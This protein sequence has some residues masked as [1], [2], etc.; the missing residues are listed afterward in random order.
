MSKK[1]TPAPI[2]AAPIKTAMVLAAGMGNRMR[3]LT[4]STPKPL[5]PMLGR[6]L[7][8]WTFDRL[9]AGGITDF[10]V[11][12]HYLGDQ[13]AAHFK[14]VPDVT[15]SPE[16]DLLETGGGVKNALPLLGTDP[17][18]VAN[19][20]MIWLDGP[21]PAVNRLRNAF[22]PDRMD[23]LLLLHPVAA[24]WGDYNGAGDYSL[25]ADGRATRRTEGRVVPLM[26]AG[27]SIM[28][29]DVYADAPDGP[30]SNLVIFDKAQEEG[31]LFGLVHDGE[32][33]HIGTPQAL[34]DCAHAIE[35]GWT[36]AQTR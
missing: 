26:Y 31:R 32:W 20:D 29:P 23:V 9:R 33:Y 14:D 18:I 28:K 1:E 16:A 12:S 15:L 30:F 11:N 2:K 22:D 4:D 7:I 5:I 36:H 24:A 27:V 19:A 34:S 17:F 25:D 6:P 8:D 10:V 35:R 3:P 13:I 21:T